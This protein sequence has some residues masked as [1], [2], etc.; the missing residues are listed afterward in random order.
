MVSFAYM[1]LI[2]CMVLFCFFFSCLGPL[3][4]QADGL[5]LPN[6][7]AG[8]PQLLAPTAAFKPALLKGLKVFADQ[9]FKMDFLIDPGQGKVSTDESTRLIKYFLAGLTIPNGDLWVNLSP[10]EKNRIIPESFGQTT[11][12][13]DVLSQDY[14]LKQ[15]TASL[16]Y[17]ESASGKI[18]WQKVY[19]QAQVKF[20][21]TNI[22]VNTFNKVWIVPQEAVVYENKNVAYIAQAKL[23]VMLEEDYLAVQKNADVRNDVG[24]IGANIIREIVIPILEREVNEGAHFT[25]L[26]QVYHALILATW[27]KKKI[28]ASLIAKAYVDQRKIQ[29][30]AVI[31]AKAGIQNIESIYQQ[32]IQTFKKGVYNYIKEEP[33]PTSGEIIPRKYFSGGAGFNLIDA[34]MKTEVVVH[35]PDSLQT[36]AM[37]V[38]KVDFGM[39]TSPAMN[40]VQSAEESGKIV[41]RIDGV[42][43]E[44]EPSGINPVGML[45]RGIDLRKEP[46]KYEYGKLPGKEFYRRILQNGLVRPMDMEGQGNL[47]NFPGQ[48]SFSFVAIT[49]KGT[50]AVGLLGPKDKDKVAF[51]VKKTFVDEHKLEFEFVG[52]EFLDMPIAGDRIRSSGIPIKDYSN[53]GIFIYPDEVLFNG[54]IPAEAIEGVIVHPKFINILLTWSK[55][56]GM[57]SFPIY[58]LGDHIR[59]GNHGPD[60]LFKFVK[61]SPAMNAVPASGNR[62]EVI[63]RNINGVEYRFEE[64]DLSPVGLLGRGIKFPQGQGQ[65]NEE[66]AFEIYK[67]IRERGL[68][69]PFEMKKEHRDVGNAV[70]LHG[71]TSFSL[72]AD[73][74]FGSQAITFFG[75]SRFSQNQVTFLVG[76]DYV[77]QHRNDFRFVGDAGYEFI[78]QGLKKLNLIAED[79]YFRPRTADEEVQALKIVPPEAILGAILYPSQIPKFLGYDRQLGLNHL[80]IYVFKKHLN[81]NVSGDGNKLYKLALDPLQDVVTAVAKEGAQPNPAMNTIEANR[82]Q[83]ITR[84][85]DEAQYFFKAANLKPKG[86][87]MRGIS[88]YSGDPKEP[89]RI[90]EFIRTKGLMSERERGTL[91]RLQGVVGALHFQAPGKV[92][93]SLTPDAIFTGSALTFFGS[94]EESITFILN[95]DYVK[96]HR[97]QF[98]FAGNFMVGD[99]DGMESM[100]QEGLSMYGVDVLQ[101]AVREVLK[102]QSIIKPDGSVSLVGAFTDEIRSTKAVPPEAIMAIVVHPKML[103]T[104]LAWDK[105]LDLA[106]LPIYVRTEDLGVKRD[107]T[108]LYQLQESTEVG[109]DAKPSSAMNAASSE[110][111]QGVFN[112]DEFRAKVDA[113]ARQGKMFDIS[114][115]ELG[116]PVLKETG[117]M[118]NGEMFNE[119][120]QDSEERKKR[121]GFP[122]Y[123]GLGIELFLSVMQDEG[124]GVW[125]SN[126]MLLIGPG[127]HWLELKSFLKGFPNQKIDVMEPDLHNLLDGLRVISQL[128]L[129]ERRRCLIRRMRAED[130]KDEERYGLIYSHMVFSNDMSHKT[131]TSE[132]VE[133]A[134]KVGGVLSGHAR[135]GVPRGFDR[136]YDHERG[137]LGVM[138]SIFR[139]VSP[140]MNVASQD[141]RAANVTSF[142]ELGKWLKTDEAKRGRFKVEVRDGKPVVTLLEGEISYDE[143]REKDKGL[144]REGDMQAAKANLDSTFYNLRKIGESNLSQKKL[145]IVG[146]GDHMVELMEFLMMENPPDIYIVEPSL[147]NISN[148]VGLLKNPKDG[149][150]IV[151]LRDTIQSVEERDIDIIYSHLVLSY[152]VIGRNNVTSVTDNVRAILKPGGLLVKGTYDLDADDLEGFDQVAGAFY[153]Y[154]Y[155]KQI[156]EADKFGEDDL[157]QRPSAAMNAASAAENEKV[158]SS[159]EEAQIYIRSLE[160]SYRKFE[161]SFR[162]EDYIIRLTGDMPKKEIFDSDDHDFLGYSIGGFD[163]GVRENFDGL[164]ELFND[165]KR[166]SWKEHPILIVGPGNHWLEAD[167][168]IERLPDF[169]KMV[170]LDF[171]IGNID[172]G[173]DKIAKWPK[174]IRER[175]VV[176][177][178]TISALDETETYGL[179]YAHLVLLSEILGRQLPNAIE[180]IQKA[181][182]PAG[183][184]VV[185]HASALG[186]FPGFSKTEDSMI[187]QKDS[188]GGIDLNSLEERLQTRGE[189]DSLKFPV[190]LNEASIA[191]MAARLTS[192]TPSI[193]SIEP[194][195]T[196]AQFW[197]N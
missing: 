180:R 35:L 2:R 188:V 26:R 139:K 192:L 33:D 53:R 126:P 116:N 55:E 87:L 5:A 63:I 20:G 64:S 97:E 124:D 70:T 194:N 165:P 15:L 98:E 141:I 96:R 31:P 43:Y 108:F 115:N 117:D 79:M 47:T 62:S 122:E 41:K 56:L 174:S 60:D 1:N 105:A 127:D 113:V 78:Q 151:L 84:T 21:T 159:K 4:A 197:L 66:A 14:I 104:V 175:C 110:A 157:R 103:K 144:I 57:P 167:Q 166:S 181:L 185:D 140:A 114:F 58:V 16:I 143:D 86:L 99:G 125:N 128:P 106:H 184:L 18:F 191:A 161:I 163:V 155:R 11:M 75:P 138:S 72:S 133:R 39:P 25:Q 169:K 17:P 102:K 77:I 23:K 129:E 24:S 9:P 29:G 195:I 170:F 183:F 90:Y 67:D 52:R 28:K 49:L 19:A 154:I 147:A 172:M 85:I 173:L 59:E 22:P 179:V 7:Q 156:G 193:T 131:G 74:G 164:S 61:S 186:S 177:R 142:E 12:G 182:R 44:F 81:E 118:P 187:L 89:F 178:D 3:P 91:N 46:G 45:V 189:G 10:Y 162:G 148:W 27:Y 149:S 32:Y 152:E 38:A 8:L 69:P 168:F 92:A 176:R 94:T 196:P 50:A 146:P 40:V 82:P 30:L 107:A 93:F 158:F 88:F 190:N 101:E 160:G 135:Y 68:V 145:M 121:Y 71:N 48:V 83:E 109:V 120:P 132:K 42:D 134:L 136:Y 37:A 13:V 153:T 51:I 95:P 54:I 65:E 171:S 76:S 100:F 130:M 137:R 112:M 6:R 123:V 36:S 73:M 111:N 150:K 34:A 80:P 119:I